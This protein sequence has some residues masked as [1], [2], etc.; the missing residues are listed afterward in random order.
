MHCDGGGLYLQVTPSKEDRPDNKS[1]LFRYATGEI[2]TSRNGKPRPV[3]RAMGL[4]SYPDVSLA[5]AREKAAGARKLREDGRDPIKARDD[6]RA[7]Q[8]AATAKAMTFD[9][10]RDAYLA[11]HRVGWRS[12][13]HGKQWARSLDMYGADLEIFACV[14]RRRNDE[15]VACHDAPPQAPAW[16][17]RRK[18]GA[19]NRSC[20]VAIPIRRESRMKGGREHRV[21]LAPAALRVIERQQHVRENDFVFPGPQRHGLSP[22]AIVK[23]LRRMGRDFTVHGFRAT[24]RDWAAER[25]SYPREV[26]EAALAHVVGSK[27]EA[28]YQRGDLFEKRGKL[29]DAW[30]KYCTSTPVE[31]GQV[32]PLRAV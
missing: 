3:E 9:Q 32:V 26:A 21:P 14:K 2:K 19:E 27:V 15:A 29:M 10:C 1:W 16:W 5:D 18:I 30:A 11:S 25:T 28:A 20:R 6:E 23:L 22:M 24:F 8:A 31:Q 7:A 17:P 12:A 4:G 13:K